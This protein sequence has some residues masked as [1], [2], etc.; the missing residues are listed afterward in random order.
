MTEIRPIRTDE[1]YEQAL[2]EVEQLV[3]LD[4]DPNAPVGKRL[5]LQAVLGEAYEEEHYPI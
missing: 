1:D 2:A 5:D 4:P 3:I